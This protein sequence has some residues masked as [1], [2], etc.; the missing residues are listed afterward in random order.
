V[1]TPSDFGAR[2]KRPTHP[3]LLDELA[4]RFMDRGW[5]IKAMHRLMVLSRT[6][7]MSNAYNTTFAETDVNNDLLWHFPQRRLTAEEIRDSLLM[8]SGTLDD[9]MMNEPHPFP[10]EYKREY[11]QH[12]PFSAVYDNNHRSVYVMQQRFKKHPF[13]ALFDGADTNASTAERYVSITPLQS[14]FFMNNAFVSEQAG[15]FA[16]H[17]MAARSTDS[18]R[19]DLAYRVALGR[20]ASVD[21][22]QAA[23]GYLNEYIQKLK[24]T[25][26]PAD[27]HAASALTSYVRALFGSNEFM[28]VD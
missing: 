15:T 21:E 11:T 24:S 25:T 5:S 13:F 10:P 1:Q 12:F 2:G 19:I 17:L 20:P 16:K 18:D 14:L 4:I 9:K 3:E 7:Q 6:Y 8:V 27:G 26:Q 23:Q 22:L 28:F